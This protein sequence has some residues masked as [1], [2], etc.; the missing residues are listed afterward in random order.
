MLGEDDL[1]VLPNVGPTIADR[2]V[3][4]GY[5]SFK[6][7][8]V[9]PPGQLSTDVNVEEDEAKEMIEAARGRVS[10][11]GFESGKKVLQSKNTARKFGFRLED[12]DDLL[13]GGLETRSISHI[14]GNEN[15]GRA[16]LM[17]HLAVHTQF[18][19]EYG[20]LGGS[21]VYFNTR[22]V[23]RPERIEEIVDGLSEADRD[24]LATS[25]D[26]DRGSLKE[27]VLKNIYVYSPVSVNEQLL[28]TERFIP[29]LLGDL[30]EDRPLSVILVDSLMYNFRIMY[31][32]RG[33]LAQRQQKVN[34][35]LHDLKRI[36]NRENA[37]IVIT[38]SLTSGGKPYGGNIVLFSTTHGIRLKKTSGDK[39]WAA[40]EDAPNLATGEVGF[41][42]DKDGIREA[43]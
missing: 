24:I 6:G 15:S 3:E 8:A 11:G 31:E 10:V 9:A 2:L 43:E 37:G 36:G 19:E 34:K 39:R 18:P 13:G 22:N 14:Y 7:I 38:N 40:L 17:H 12:F 41:Y 30:D 16:A 23:F 42:V 25:L 29:N 21:V 26:V 27:A 4:Q 5:Q 20:G 35:H 33:E 32:G 28:A 1:T